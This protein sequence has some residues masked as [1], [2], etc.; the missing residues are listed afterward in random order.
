MQ[1]AF[2]QRDLYLGFVVGAKDNSKEMILVFSPCL[3][4][5]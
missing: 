5:P 1:D 2:S 3:A 4:L